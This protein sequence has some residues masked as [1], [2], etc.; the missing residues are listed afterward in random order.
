MTDLAQV[1]ADWREKAAILRA[2]GHKAQGDSIDAVVDD[3]AGAA[4][5]YLRW[6]S[7]ENAVLRSGR[8]VAWLRRRFPAWERAGHARRRGR[9]REYRML[10]VPVDVDHIAAREAG[11]RAARQRLRRAQ[12]P[13]GGRRVDRRPGHQA[14]AELPEA[15]G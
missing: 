14:D 9:G 8:S 13:A 5:E 6:M 11:K 15:A 12:G 1:L 10:V 2:N 3:V 7:E 4:E